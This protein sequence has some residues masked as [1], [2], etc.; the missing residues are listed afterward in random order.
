MANV[1]YVDFSNA[2]LTGSDLSEAQLFNQSLT[3]T[4]A[5]LPDGITRGR[6]QNVIFNGDAENGSS[7]GWNLVNGSNITAKKYSNQMPEKYGQWYFQLF[8]E[9]TQ[10]TIISQGVDLYDYRYMIQREPVIIVISVD[11]VPKPTNI[12]IFVTTFDRYGIELDAS[13]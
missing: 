7:I 10:K 5:I 11:V 8:A 9:K 2:D 12:D 13:K 3:F 6:A 4:D 1:A